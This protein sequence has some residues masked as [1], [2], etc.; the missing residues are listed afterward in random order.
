MC[1]FR[2]CSTHVKKGSFLL[3]MQFIKML[4]LAML[5]CHSCLGVTPLNALVKGS[6]AGM[7]VVAGC[8]LTD[9]A[10][11]D[12]WSLGCI[13]AELA[14]KRPLF[15]CNSPS[16]LLAQVH[17]LPSSSLKLQSLLGRCLSCHV[18]NC[19]VVPLLHSQHIA[20]TPYSQ[21]TNQSI[22]AEIPECQLLHKKY[23]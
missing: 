1:T 16:E 14:L 10:A 19:V 18:Q 3:T 7:Q 13:L 8:G 17:N 23:Q 20:V 15:P 12:A 22:L 6:L 5:Q 21:E 11:L 2:A 4:L 9:G